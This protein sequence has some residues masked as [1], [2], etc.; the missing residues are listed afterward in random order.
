MRLFV[1]LLHS[2]LIVDFL[3][4]LDGNCY[5]FGLFLILKE[6]FLL[7]PDLKQVKEGVNFILFKVIMELRRLWFL[8]HFLFL[9]SVLL[10]I[11]VLFQLSF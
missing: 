11:R 10:L 1:F 4:F 5:I 2:R 9:V 7:F 8:C 6:R 3:R